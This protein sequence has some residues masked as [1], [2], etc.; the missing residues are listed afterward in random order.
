MNR[1]ELRGL[2]EDR[3]LDAEALLK[4]GRWSG[5]YYLAGHDV[6]TLVDAAGLQKER[7][8]SIAA[9]QALSDNWLVVKDWKETDRYQ[10]KNEDEARRLHQAV[11]ENVNGVLPWIKM[12]W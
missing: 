7:G 6:D 10:A 1:V 3:V 4:E 2:A 5:A 8:L 12:H 11:T 9:N